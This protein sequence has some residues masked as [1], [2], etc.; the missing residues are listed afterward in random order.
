MATTHAEKDKQIKELKEMVRALEKKSKNETTD[1]SKLENTQVVA[2][3][4]PAGNLVLVSLQ[5]DEKTAV[6]TKN[7]ELSGPLQ[8][9]YLKYKTE[10]EIHNR[11]NLKKGSK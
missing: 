10:Q 5:F 9:Q 8:S 3:T 1:A 7:T 6:V 4:N 11:E 2:I